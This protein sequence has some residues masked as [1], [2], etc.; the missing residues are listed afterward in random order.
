DSHAEGSNNASPLMLFAT[1]GDSTATISS[2]VA[3]SYVRMSFDFSRGWASMPT[4]RVASPQCSHSG[5]V[6]WGSGPIKSML[7]AFMTVF[8][9]LIEDQ[10]KYY[11]V[12]A[13]NTNNT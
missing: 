4:R 8:L 11:F 10:S 6:P 7:S 1:G 12:Y 13:A 3:H 9:R 5:P 2:H